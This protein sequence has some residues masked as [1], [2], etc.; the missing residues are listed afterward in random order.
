MYRTV[1]KLIVQQTGTQFVFVWLKHWVS[2]VSVRLIN[3]FPFILC[4]TILIFMMR[5]QLY[6]SI[7]FFSCIRYFVPFYGDLYE[8]KSLYTMHFMAYGN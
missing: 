7:F 1:E 3:I 4:K 6:F 2:R 8:L 5:A